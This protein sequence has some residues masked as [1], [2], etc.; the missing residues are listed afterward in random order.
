VADDGFAGKEDSQ[1]SGNVLANDSDPDGDA[2]GVTSTGTINT[3]QGGTVDIA[4]DGSFVYTPAPDFNGTD[5]FDYTV[6]D[7]NGGTATATV[8]LQ[9]VPA[10]DAPVLADDGATTPVEAAVTLDVLANDGDPEGDP[11]TIASVTQ[12]ANGSV[13]INADGTLAYTPDTGFAGGDSFTYTVDDGNGGSGTATVTI[14]VGDGITL[15]GTGG[16]DILIGTDGDDVLDGRAGDDTLIGGAGADFLDGGAS[17]DTVD[18]SASGAG[19]NVDLGLGTGSG[20]G[21]D[22]EGDTLIAI[23]D[24]VGSAFDD[25]IQGGNGHN[26]LLGGDGDDAL[27]GRGGNDILVGGAGAD[28][29]DGG[30][31]SD[32]ADYQESAAGVTIDLAGGTGSGGDAE[33]DILFNIKDV[34]G[35]DF[36]DLLTGNKNE[37][38]LSGGAGDDVLVGGAGNDVLDGGPGNDILK[39][40]TGQDTF[41]FESGTGTDSDSITDFTGGEDVIDLTAYGLTSTA[42]LTITNDGGNAV[43]KL[44]GGD[45]VTLLATDETALTDADFVF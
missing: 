20:A 9:V 21:G 26:L 37:N 22:A 18:Y 16:P 10:N 41:V 12:G 8:T 13:A 33:G 35:S 4:V 1:I 27:S 45:S 36:D 2:L 5:S 44:P 43:I 32:L 15:D 38:E 23:E 6:S 42:D 11:L 30:G 7:G 29:L 40:G 25:V 31:G 28:I 19:V 14:A 39:G 17:T 24:V 34:A 3:A